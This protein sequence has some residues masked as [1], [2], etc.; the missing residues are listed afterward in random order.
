MTSLASNLKQITRTRYI[1]DANP[2]L[3]TLRYS[4]YV[5]GS[6]LRTRTLGLVL[7]EG[8]PGVAL[9]AHASVM[10]G[11]TAAGLGLA[12][13]ALAHVRCKRI[14]EQLCEQTQTMIMIGAQ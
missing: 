12:V 14:C 7:A 3:P 9:L 5:I 1:Y 2:T 11:A 6:Q 10:R 4:G 8:P 13:H